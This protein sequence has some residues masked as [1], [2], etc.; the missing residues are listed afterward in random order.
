[1]IEPIN[2]LHLGACISGKHHL[3]G[4]SELVVKAVFHECTDLIVERAFIVD[5]FAQLVS[6]VNTDLRTE[7][8][9]LLC[10]GSATGQNHAHECHKCLFH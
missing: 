10:H 6:V 9:R 7:C 8:E 2:P 1:M 4:N 3:G 5:V